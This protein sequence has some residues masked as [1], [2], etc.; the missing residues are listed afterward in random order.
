MRTAG[1]AHLQKIAGPASKGPHKYHDCVMAGATAASN[2][3]YLEA[4]RQRFVSGGRAK[5]T[6]FNECNPQRKTPC[7]QVFAT[8]IIVHVLQLE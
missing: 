3:Q 4:E 8:T 7:G 2:P 1:G 5:H 6:S